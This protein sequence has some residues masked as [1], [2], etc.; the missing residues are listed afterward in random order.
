[1]SNNFIVA[2]KTDHV[3][4]CTELGRQP[5]GKLVSNNFIV[6][7]IIINKT[8]IQSTENSEKRA[9]SILYD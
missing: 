6:A 9:G 5:R 1:M 4:N 2:L 7:W 8:I 3:T